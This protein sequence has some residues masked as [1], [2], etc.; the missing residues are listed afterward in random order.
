M[1]PATD[2]ARTRPRPGTT[3]RTR[4]YGARCVPEYTG[5]ANWRV[6]VPRLPGIDG[7]LMC[8]FGPE[9]KAL[10][11][12]VTDELMYLG[13]V[14]PEDAH[15]RPDAGT[16]HEEPAKR[17]AAFTGPVGEAVASVTDP[18]SV[19]HTRISQV[20]VEDPWHVGRIVLADDAAHAS[21]P[22]LAQGAAMAVEDALVLADALRD[23]DAVP[24][25]LAAWEARRRPRA[26][27]VQAAVPRGPQAGDGHAHDARGG[28]TPEDR[29]PGRRARPG[30]AL[31]GHPL[32]GPPA[33]PPGR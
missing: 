22:H 2:R 17:L 16:A 6:A 14:F 9:A 33:P 32:T 27:W 19:V 8:V 31:L 30:P 13:A 25:A 26:L 7:V 3:L 15:Y 23:E 12:P 10:L 28:R 18:A 1:R 5:F 29:R 21:A 11:T 24:A 20:T 4:L